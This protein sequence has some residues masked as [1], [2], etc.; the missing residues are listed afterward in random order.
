MA[1][2]NISYCIASAVFLIAG[3]IFLIEI[4]IKLIEFINPWEG[5]FLDLGFLTDI[6][7]VGFYLFIYG[8]FIWIIYCYMGNHVKN[9]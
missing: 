1:L 3:V 5:D 2:A 9:N 7:G 6:F 4:F 8:Y